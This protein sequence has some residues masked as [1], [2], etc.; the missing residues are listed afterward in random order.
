ML[1]NFEILLCLIRSLVT[2]NFVILYIVCTV[3]YRGCVLN[4]ECTVTTVSRVYTAAGQ[5]RRRYSELEGRETGDKHSIGCMYTDRCKVLSYL[6][7]FL[8]KRSAVDWEK[9]YIFINF[10]Y[11]VI[12]LDFII[13][14]TVKWYKSNM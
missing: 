14:F 13:H 1:L 12:K 5:Y 3:S 6:S 4:M 11:S 2:L 9:K 8:T 10:S 7:L